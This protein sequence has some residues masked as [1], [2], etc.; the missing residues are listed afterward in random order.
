MATVVEPAFGGTTQSVVV[1]VPRVEDQLLDA[2]IASDAVT[3]LLQQIGRQ[4]ACYAPVAVAEGVDAEKI[5]DEARGD[6]ERVVVAARKRAP[7]PCDQLLGEMLRLPPADRLE[8]DPARAARPPVVDE[9]VLGLEV[10]A[11]SVGGG[12]EQAV[13]VEDEADGQF[14]GVRLLG[15]RP[16][17]APDR[18]TRS[19]RGL[20]AF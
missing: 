19:M 10:A 20:T 9:V 15:R 11:A 6:D 17:F 4:Q 1:G 2:H 12:V 14:P 13:E 8:A 3:V 7:G 18:R 16:V 5:E